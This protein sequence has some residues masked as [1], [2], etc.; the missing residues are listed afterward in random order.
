[1]TS[2]LAQHLLVQLDR[3]RRENVEKDI[4]EKKQE[5]RRDQK[6]EYG[7][8]WDADTLLKVCGQ[9][10]YVWSV[11]TELW[12]ATPCAQGG[13]SHS[14]GMVQMNPICS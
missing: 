14:T 11:I 13:I 4:R 10:K 5:Q 2:S 12:N 7:W 1:M 3:E 8:K 9:T 6:K